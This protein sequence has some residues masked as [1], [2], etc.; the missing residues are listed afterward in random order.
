MPGLAGSIF[1]RKVSV[2]RWSV[3]RRRTYRGG[4]RC[5]PSGRS[6][7]RGADVG[8]MRIEKRNTIILEAARRRHDGGCCCSDGT[9]RLKS[10]RI[11]PMLISPVGRFLYFCF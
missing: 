8:R 4:E 10:E 11:F 9:D 1:L 7:S 3:D 2:H 6:A 5:A